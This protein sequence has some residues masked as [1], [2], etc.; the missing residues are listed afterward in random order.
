M[1]NI[2]QLVDDDPTTCRAGP[3]VWPP[4]SPNLNP[5]DFYLWGLL[6]ILVYATEIPD[7]AVLQWRIE[8]GCLIVQNELNGICNIPR[9]VRRRT[10]NVALNTLYGECNELIFPVSSLCCYISLS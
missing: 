9:A 1:E 7:V 10:Q 4:R 8:K 5:L 3:V 6:K 2:L